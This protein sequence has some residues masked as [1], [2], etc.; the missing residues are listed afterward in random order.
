MPS[1]KSISFGFGL[2]A[3]NLV[4]NEE[5][6][7]NN[8]RSLSTD[9][10]SSAGIFY[11]RDNSLLVSLLYAGKKDNMLRLNIYPGVISFGRISSGLFMLLDRSN[12]LIA[13]IQFS[14]F[15]VAFAK[16]F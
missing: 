3:K 5:K 13:G 6:A 11:D 9:L 2:T 1:G 7:R 14:F 15:P 12:R 16:T 4:D 8:L 10:V